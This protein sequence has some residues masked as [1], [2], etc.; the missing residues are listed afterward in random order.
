MFLLFLNVL[1]QVGHELL[2]LWDELW[3]AGLEV[4]EDLQI[5]LDLLMG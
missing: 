1:A 3:S 5:L 4:L 2:N